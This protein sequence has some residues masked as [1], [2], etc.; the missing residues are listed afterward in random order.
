MKKCKHGHLIHDNCFSCLEE[1]Y[2]K[3]NES[4]A[5]KALQE[6]MEKETMDDVELFLQHCKSLYEGRTL[7]KLDRGNWVDVKNVDITKLSKFPRFYR[8]KQRGIRVHVSR[9]G[10]RYHFI[11]ADNPDPKSHVLV[12]KYYGIATIQFKDIKR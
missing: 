10:D 1:F 2:S 5:L 4:E 3:D 7:Q 6:G 12:D 11:D 9:V 8:T